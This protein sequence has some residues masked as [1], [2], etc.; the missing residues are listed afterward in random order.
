MPST[1]ERRLEALET[2]LGGGGGCDRCRGLLVTVHNA[3]TG[4]LHS[5]RWNGAPLGEDELSERREETKCPR[6]GGKLDPG[7]YPVIRIGGARRS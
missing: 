7:E 5:A 6:C 3:I 4:Q 1:L 2:A